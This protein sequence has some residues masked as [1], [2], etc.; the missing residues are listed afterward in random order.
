MIFTEN[1]RK[2]IKLSQQLFVLF[3]KLNIPRLILKSAGDFAPQ[4]HFRVCKKESSWCSNDFTSG[5]SSFNK[6]SPFWALT[7]LWQ[8]WHSNFHSIVVRNRFLRLLGAESINSLNII[9]NLIDAIT[10]KM[11]YFTEVSETDEVSLRARNLHRTQKHFQLYNEDKT[12]FLESIVE[13][14][15]VA[16]KRDARDN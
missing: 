3:V 11:R 6:M 14:I 9:D 10:N 5:A 4:V 12:E 1:Q 7:N 2:T 13:R 16:D 8:F 15:D